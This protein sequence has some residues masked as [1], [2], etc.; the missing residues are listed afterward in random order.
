MNPV[1]N[2]GI[3]YTINNAGEIVGD[4][5]DGPFYWDPIHGGKDLSTLPRLGNRG[6]GAQGINDPIAGGTFRIVG[7]LGWSSGVGHE[8]WW[9]HA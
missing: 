6:Q 8:V 1:C 9:P 5:C 2:T 7:V 3:A 4:S